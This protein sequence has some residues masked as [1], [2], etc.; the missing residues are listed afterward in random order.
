M[1]EL[2]HFWSMSDRSYSL[3]IRGIQL[4]GMLRLDGVQFNMTY[5]VWGDGAENDLRD[6]LLVLLTSVIKDEIL[7]QEKKAEQINLV[8]I[9][10]Y[11]QGMASKCE[12]YYETLI[13][14]T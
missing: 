13:T 2:E 5:Y 8:T 4:M 11:K 14:A 3:G 7:A 10:I 6:G 9:N 12:G 1:S